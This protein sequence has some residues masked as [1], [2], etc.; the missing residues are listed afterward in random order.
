MSELTGSGN[1]EQALRP[2]GRDEVIASTI[3]AA[4]ELFSKRNPSQVSVREIAAGAGVSHALVHRY[5]GSK[6]D[7]FRA[8]LAAAR[9][10]AADYWM[11]EHGLSQTAGTFDSTLPPGRYVR[12]AVRASLDGVEISP[13][14]LKLPHSDEMLKL[15]VGSGLPPIEAQAPFDI[16]I[17]LSAVT[18]MAAGMAIAEDFFLAQSGLQDEDPT[19]VHS[20]FNRL[21]RLNLSLA[22]TRPRPAE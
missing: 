15:L 20:E 4:I 19:Y 5:M 14:D 11:Q 7:I 1:S 17:V 16:R 18:A 6:Q 13:E 21:I 9:Q 8:A 3:Q 2:T 22:D 12:M 10:E